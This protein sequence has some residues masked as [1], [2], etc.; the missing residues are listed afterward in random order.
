MQKPCES[1][2]RFIRS[3]MVLIIL[4]TSIPFFLAKENAPCQVNNKEKIKE[5]DPYSQV[6]VEQAMKDIASQEYNI[7]W[8]SQDSVYKSPNRA[9]NFRITFTPDRVAVQPRIPVGS[10]RADWFLDLKLKNIQFDDKKTF[11]P[12][13]YATPV[14]EKNK[15]TYNHNGNFAIEYINSENGLRQNF[16]INKAPREDAGLISIQIQVGGSVKARKSSNNEIFFSLGKD[17]ADKLVYKDL[18]VWDAN[19]RTLNAWMDVRDESM[20]EIKVD[21]ENA[22]LPITIDPLST[23]TH[24]WVTY[25]NNAGDK[26]GIS[27]ASAGD[28]NND[29]YSDIMIASTKCDGTYADEGAVYIYHGGPYG[30]GNSPAIV[31]MGADFAGQGAAN[32]GSSVSSAGDINGD[33]CSDIIIGAPDYDNG[34][35]NRGAAFI[36]YG[37]NNIGITAAG[38]SILSGVNANDNFGVSVSG[39][40]DINGD[41][42]S[43]VI[44]GVQGY[45]VAVANDE[46]GAAFIYFGSNAGI[47][48]GSSPSQILQG[49]NSA[50]ES[51]T[52]YFDN[53]DLFG[54][55]VAGAGDVNG[56]GYSDVLVT[57]SQYEE[58]LGDNTATDQDE[59][60]VYVYHGGPT[61]INVTA[62]IV[63][64]GN[65]DRV[66]F[67]V[68]IGTAGDVNGDGY[69]DIVVSAPDYSIYSSNGGIVPQYGGAVFIFSGSASGITGSVAN[70]S[71]NG[72]TLYGNVPFQRFGTCVRCAGDVNGDGFA[73]VIIG[74]TTYDNN[75]A[76]DGS[77]SG[78]ITGNTF[79]YYGRAGILGGSVVS[80]S[81]SLLNIQSPQSAAEFGVSV[82]SAGDI[83]GDGFSDVIVGASDYDN[84]AVTNL[85]CV[86]SFNG[87][88]AGLSST[89]A[90]MKERNQV[91]A[92]LGI[93]VASAGDVNDDGLG[94][95]I[96]GANLYDNGATINSGAVFIYH[97]LNN[98][99]I[100]NFSSPASPLVG[101]AGSNFGISVAL[102]GDVNGDGYS[103]IIVG[104]NLAGVNNAGAA[105]IYHGSPS[106]ISLTPSTTLTGINA[107]DNFGIS[108]SGA[109]DINWDGYSD[110]VVGANL[111]ESSPVETNEG[112]AFVYYGSTS[113][114]NTALGPH[115]L[116]SNQANANFGISVAHAGDVNQDG[117]SDVVVG[118]DLYDNG[119]MDEG[120]AFLYCG[121]SHG[122][123]AIPITSLESNQSNAHFG[124]SVAYAGDI[125]GDS[126]SDVIVGAHLYDNVH[127]DA[128]AA[129]V[130]HGSASGLNSTPAMTL[131]GINADDHFGISVSSAGDVN[132]DGYDDVIVGANLYDNGETDEGGAFV[133]H[134]SNTGILPVPNVVLE[135]NQAS[136]NFGIS[137]A[138][139][140]DL[141]G[142][143]YADAITGASSYNGGQA[144]EGRIYIYL[145]NN[146][147]T[148]PLITNRA[149]SHNTGSTSFITASNLTDL[150][151]GIE[152]QAKSYLG[153]QRGKL[154][155]ETRGSGQSWSLSPSGYVTN[156]IGSTSEQSGYSS[157]SQNGSTVLFTEPAAKVLIPYYR[158]TRSRMR[159]KYD[160]V[161]ALTGQ[162]YGPWRNVERYGAALIAAQPYQPIVL[163]EKITSFN[164]ISNECTISLQ[165]QTPPDL[166]F[167][168][169]IVEASK[170]GQLFSE[171]DV[172]T[173]YSNSNVTQHYFSTI[174]QETKKTFYRLKMV[175]LDGKSDYSKSL[176]VRSNCGAIFSVY[177]NPVKRGDNL[178]I[179]FEANSNY[180]KIVTVLLTDM[181]GRKFSIG[182]FA[183]ESN[184]NCQKTIN[185]A[186]LEK[187]I[188]RLEI[189]DSTGYIEASIPIVID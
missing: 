26:L 48:S 79:I 23:S 28:V 141:N 14:L 186:K 158:L 170:D 155:W 119:E 174:R 13:K 4:G 42:Y 189:I 171:I 22:K 165:W 31:L 35:T 102:A 58:G 5:T 9:Q 137:V 161:T 125:N 2:T 54:A 1:V 151:F 140:G 146:K 50:T 169:F 64:E 76:A 132:G 136:A 181:L 96:I 90:V 129:F 128:G 108:V 111:Y 38:F 57:A 43:D 121:S 10:P 145:G 83:N 20:L 131:S 124:I 80:S 3:G 92:N 78:G 62:A 19:G 89:P 116:E 37:S 150:N 6:W 172:V 163:T 74:A 30:P 93:S 45:D 100:N 107:G 56:D 106:G 153:T 67:G 68:S 162:V 112:A 110:V 24:D 7:S 138:G 184:I 97:G 32:F 142:D 72:V 66:K 114:I 185:S 49:P 183:I 69:S 95:V 99:G 70:A 44:I 29:G 16:I 175:Y 18:K 39:A 118:A 63:L 94:D 52:W 33:G 85:G 122:I 36:F 103:D 148:G 40:G 55:V 143:G 168:K 154:V 12:D 144:G 133:Y 166:P 87:S 41:H 113:G 60:A 101:A 8:D 130:H 73:D 75:R 34:G 176:L 21:A 53:S 180:G 65:R 135:S 82:A 160:P 159:I 98:G 115:R 147:T 59:G 164:A 178:T 157:L 127:T 17:Y 167:K 61:G 84:G 104:A 134:G 11:F 46:R 156:S 182:Q 152:L 139:A 120:A 117:W 27:I 179:K 109:G 123:N 88:A 187:G 77:A 51:G 149:K 173:A 177:P 71:I 126:Y 25:G 105:Y 15:I 188:Y 91:D 47:V 86:Y 81:T